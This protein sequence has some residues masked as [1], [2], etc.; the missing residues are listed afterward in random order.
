MFYVIKL[1]V[2]LSKCISINWVLFFDL[3]DFFG[4]FSLLNIHDLF[5]FTA[6]EKFFPF[7][8]LI[9]FFS[10]FKFF[11]NFLQLFYFIFLNIKIFL[12][13][14]VDHSLKISFFLMQFMTVM[15]VSVTFDLM[16]FV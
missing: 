5:I 15:S 13:E 4:Y 9:I 14:M 16:E 1:F 7:F 3:S 6:E 2:P 11:F 10:T 12:F 8:F